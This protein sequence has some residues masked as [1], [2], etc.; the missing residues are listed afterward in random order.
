MRTPPE[1]SNGF[2]YDCYLF[3]RRTSGR[4][5]MEP[6][7]INFAAASLSDLPASEQRS[8]R[9]S[10]TGTALWAK[11]HSA[12]S[13]INWSKRMISKSMGRAA[14]LSE[15]CSR[16]I[17]SS[18]GVRMCNFN[19]FCPRGVCANTAALR[20]FGPGDPTEQV[21]HTDEIRRMVK[22]FCNRSIASWRLRSGCKFDPSSRQARC[23]ETIFN[24][25]LLCVRSR[26]QPIWRTVLH[27][28][29]RHAPVLS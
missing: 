27:P 23:S 15:E 14:F 10:A 20:K 5:Q 12:G 19:V 24:Q 29:F 6:S 1:F 16:P 9:I 8:G 21:S 18:R 3:M 7:D 28:V 25:P 26:L 13:N 22:R 2:L 11:F 17:F 4:N